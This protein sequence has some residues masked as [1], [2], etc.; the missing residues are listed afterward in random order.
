MRS[1]L[2]F[3]VT[4]LLILLALV[5]NL[6]S[7]PALWWDEGWTLSVA[8]NWVE[9][10][11]YGQVQDGHLTT[12]GLEAGFPI[13]ASIALAFRLFGV[14]AEQARLVAVSFTL[15][16]LALL[17]ELASRFYN[18]SIGVATLA[19]LLLMS[20][21]IE[22]NPLLTGR[23]VLG[24]IPALSFLLGG[25]LCFI[26]VENRPWAYLPAA[27]CLW[28]LALFTKV[29][30]QPFW[31]V[32]LVIPL[33]LAI[34]RRRWKRA[35]LIAA[36]LVGSLSLYLWLQHL[37][38][39]QVTTTSVSGLTQVIALVFL[40]HTRITVLGETVRFGLP[41]LF[42]LC[43]ALYI[44]LKNSDSLRSHLEM[45]RLAFVFLVG[46]WFVWYETLSLGW[47]RYMLPP[48]FLGSIFVAAMLSDWTNQFNVAST[49]QKAG[50]ALKTFR[51]SREKIAA[52][53][54]VLLITMSFAQTVKVLYGAYV[55]D[56]DDSIKDVVRFLNTK[57]SPN[58]LIETYE[59]ELFFL[60]DRRYHYPPDQVHVDL[61]RRNSFG[62]RV[63]INYDPLAANPDYLVV[64]P[65]SK[66][67]DFYDPYL[68]TGDFRLLRD[69]SRYQIYERVR[70]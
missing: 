39:Q 36:C 32:S 33:L 7:T 24:E 4:A 61:I 53:A 17:Y 19:V 27:I 38:L 67:W 42:G 68:K 34:V 66:F 29:Q 18:R 65:Q 31:A 41:T 5:T 22:I 37:F 49:I 6:K 11:H 26:W 20:S 55:V 10:G 54:S 25:Y 46:S 8:R 60:M 59:S 45:V 47:P 9:R 28:S 58:A 12:R 62:Q 52:L 48:V 30:V 70:R 3:L 51:F 64:G 57:T 43:W 23:Q 15:A 21:H 16:A 1:Y 44:F 2:G 50:S 56:A 63:N 13:T 69:Y 40:K 35:G 14:G